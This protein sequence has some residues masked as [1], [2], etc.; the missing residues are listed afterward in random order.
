MRHI[1]VLL[2]SVFLA[3]LA[4]VGVSA[5]EPQQVG[6]ATT[7]RTCGGGTINLGDAEKRMLTLHNQERAKRDLPRFCVHPALVRA[8]EAHS[9]D[10]IQRDY[11]SHNTKG[12]N[13]SACERVRRYGYRWQVCA[14]NI[15]WGAGALGRPD[16]I[17]D[18]WMDSSGH[19][20]N[21]LNRKYREIGIGAYRGTFKRY[22][23]VTMWTVDFGDR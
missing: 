16:P 8:A 15:A 19:R 1:A 5:V 4:A 3:V 7:V 6:A 9:K 20:S 17:F 18:G 14:E 10:M 2:T 23:N 11:F 21:I 22:S 12:R 13:E